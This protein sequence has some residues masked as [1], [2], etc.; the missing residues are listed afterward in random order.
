MR[1]RNFRGDRYP[2][3]S[4]TGRSSHAQSRLDPPPRF[5][6]KWLRWRRFIILI[7]ALSLPLAGGCS[8]LPPRPE[9]TNF[10]VLTA[11]ADSGTLQPPPSIAHQLAIGLGP[12]KFPD[13]LEHLDVVTRVSPNRVELSSTE[14]WAEP[15]D[16]SFKRVLAR[17]LETL[18]GTDQV[19]QFP[20]Y[21]SV[22]LDYKV[23][24]TVERFERDGSGGT[25]LVATWL[26]RDGHN[27]RVVVSRQSNFGAIATSSGGPG[28]TAP[29]DT[30]GNSTE[31]AGASG[32]SMD[33]AAAALSS[34][35]GDL[36]KQI[37]DALTDLSSYHPQHPPN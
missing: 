15:L 6:Q 27:D 32:T 21:P 29:T 17:N 4:L 26:I 24:V 35:L 14:R 18:L 11:I 8:L 33:S 37:A 22:K 23:E 7:A 2:R 12:I 5:G 28:T 25:Q 13:Y 10:Y 9:D 3:N 16:E 30:A 36:S 1:L 19:I 34:D 20:W 31:R